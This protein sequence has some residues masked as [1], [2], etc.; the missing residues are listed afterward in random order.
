MSRDLHGAHLGLFH[1]L[2]TPI[3]GSCTPC[4]MFLFDVR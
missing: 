4:C 3:L 1:C 2:D